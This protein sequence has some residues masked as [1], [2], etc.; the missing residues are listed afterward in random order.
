MWFETEPS[1]V[2]E[3]Q[4]TL[5]ERL[6][7]RR[8]LLSKKLRTVFGDIKT[9]FETYPKFSVDYNRWFIAETHTR[10]N[11]RLVAADEVRP[12]V[13]VQTDAVTSPMGQ[14]RDFVI[15]SEPCISDH[16]SCGCIDRFARRPNLCR[17]KTSVLRLAFEVPDVALALRRFAENKCAR[18]V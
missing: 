18:D 15:R 8:T 12:F 9:I 10:L 1:R 3:P 16:F 4:F 11:G 2:H 14:P 5:A 17:G 7:E 13:S 6:V